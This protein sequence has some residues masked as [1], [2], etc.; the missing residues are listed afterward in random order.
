MGTSLS[1][2]AGDVPTGDLQL[3][4]D[5]MEAQNLNAV[6]IA[7]PGGERGYQ[8]SLTRPR[9]TG[10][11]QVY[12]GMDLAETVLRALSGGPQQLAEPLQIEDDEDDDWSHLV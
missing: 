2:I 8:V 4:A 10:G 11:W 6:T 5:E 7:H 9:S 3:I 1:E 12:Y